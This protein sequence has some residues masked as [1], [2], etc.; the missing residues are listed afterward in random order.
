[1]W[2]RGPGKS[3][4]ESLPGITP[5]SSEKAPDLELN[6]GLGNWQGTGLEET[7]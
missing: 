4:P 1:V 7:A 2:G 3:N 6:F 5:D